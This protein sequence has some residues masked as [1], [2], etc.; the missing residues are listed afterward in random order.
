MRNDKCFP[1]YKEG[2]ITFQPTYKYNPGT[3]DWDRYG[4]VGEGRE[5]TILRGER[6]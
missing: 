2:M 1:K 5:V 3:D 4:D 6:K